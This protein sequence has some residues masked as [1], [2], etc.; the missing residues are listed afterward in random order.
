MMPCPVV[1]P[2]VSF[3]T[4]MLVTT[5][6]TGESERDEDRARALFDQGLEAAESEDWPA[7]VE[8]FS[9]SYELFPLAGTLLNI[10]LYQMEA[11]RPLEAHRTLNELLERYGDDISDRSRA[12]VQRRL[13]VVDA[14]LATV[15]V[16]T[17]PE[18]ARLSIDGQP[19][20]D[21]ADGHPVFLEPG[22]HTFEAAL[23]GHED[24]SVTRTLHAGEAASVEI[25]LEPLVPA[26][27]ADEG[28]SSAGASSANGEADHD[29]AQEPSEGHTEPASHFE[30]PFS[31]DGCYD[32]GVAAP[33]PDG[34]HCLAGDCVETALPPELA[35]PSVVDETDCLRHE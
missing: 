23:D 34:E 31:I 3:I 20:S 5:A 17:R 10:G 9:Q 1:R 25:S 4:V 7:A 2:L 21:G 32:R 12:E 13:A 16:T 11:G 33:C 27:S 22:E 14:A 28:L 6:A 30:V 35:A 24:A 19:Q 15:R 18:G 26:P 29:V 8:A